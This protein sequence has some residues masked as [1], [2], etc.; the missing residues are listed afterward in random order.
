MEF[1]GSR[2][3]NS[4]ALQGFQALRGLQGFQVLRGLQGFQVLR[5]F[6]LVDHP[7]A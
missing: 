3:F 4:Q 7:T 6:Q 2:G 1:M 5:G